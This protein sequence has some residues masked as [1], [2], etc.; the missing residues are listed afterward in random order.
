ML[1]FANG[2]GLAADVGLAAG[3]A[4]AAGTVLGED[5]RLPGLVLA[6][7][8]FADVDLRVGAAIV[9][10]GEAGFALAAGGSASKIAASRFDNSAR[11]LAGDDLASGVASEAGWGAEADSGS[12]AVSGFD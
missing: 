2:A 11:R 9:G 6:E 8:V 12:V 4:L 1:G 5:L 3:A 7:V 10:F